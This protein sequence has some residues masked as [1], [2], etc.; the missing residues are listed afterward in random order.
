MFLILANDNDET[1]LAVYQKLCQHH[2]PDGALLLTD[3]D[4]VN[5][6]GWVHEQQEVVTRTL[7]HLPDGRQIDSDNITA[8]FNRLRYINP[9]HFQ[10]IHVE[11]QE[12]ALGE[13]FALL[14]SWLKSLKCKVVNPAGVRGLD[15]SSRSLL[16]WLKLAGEL[17]MPVRTARFTTNARLVPHRTFSTFQP[18]PGAALAQ[19]AYFTPVSQILVGQGPALFLETVCEET[20]RLLVVGDTVFGELKEMADVCLALAQRSNVRL[21]ECVFTR[22]AVRQENIWRCGWINPSP[23]L[24]DREISAVVNF[25]ENGHPL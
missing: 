13:M 15:G 7:L 1:A 4:L 18:P 8:V 17:G 3:A 22:S 9:A 2:G 11:D 24:C 23:Q 20:Q 14:L 6:V 10:L 19:A 16:E 21:L 25:L 12:Y 5:R